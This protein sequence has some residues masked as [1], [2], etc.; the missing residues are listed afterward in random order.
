MRWTRRDLH[1]EDKAVP[2]V[3]VY[4]VNAPECR[5]QPLLN[6]ARSPD[7]VTLGELQPR[8]MS[9]IASNARFNSVSVN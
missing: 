8:S 7:E 9:S 3:P 4:A 1:L 6:F 2:L 5:H